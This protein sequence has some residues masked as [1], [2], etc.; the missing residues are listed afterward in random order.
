MKAF[1]NRA[2]V[3]AALT[4]AAGLL[5]WGGLYL[6]TDSLCWL[7][8]LFGVPCPGCGSTRAA[9]ELFR[10]H[11]TEAFSLHPLIPLSLIILPYA[12]IRG[13]FRRRRPIAQAEKITAFGIVVLYIVVYVVR[14]ALFFPHTQPMVPL[15]SAVWPRIFRWAYSV[16]LK[17]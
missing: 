16:F 1:V 10:G 4:A 15:E 9:V 17:M 13:L 12:V 8:A 6:L 5:L 14:M 2:R 3:K 11:F 7:Q